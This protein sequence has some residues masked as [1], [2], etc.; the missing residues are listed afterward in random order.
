MLLLELL[1]GVHL[2]L[3]ACC[4]DLPSFPLL[5]MLLAFPLFNLRLAGIDLL[6][7]LLRYLDLWSGSRLGDRG[8]RL[9]GLGCFSGGREYDAHGVY[10]RGPRPRLRR[11]VVDPGICEDQ[12]GAESRTDDNECGSNPCKEDACARSHC[13]LSPM[14]GTER[15]RR[16][17]GFLHREKRAICFLKPGTFLRRVISHTAFSRS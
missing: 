6:Y 9:R 17:K 16:D 14:S 10:Q 3:G 5:R 2:A 11:N 1:L 15:T 13:G 12:A 4:S 8:A 7:L